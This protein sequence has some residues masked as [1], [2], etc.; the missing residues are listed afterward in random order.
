MNL[1]NHS[2]FNLSGVPGSQ[3]LDHLIMINADYYTPVDSMLIPDSIAP[4][5]GTPMDLRD[6]V[7]LNLHID[8]S[9]E[10]IVR[11]RGFDHNW[12][13]NTNGDVTKLAAKAISPVSG[14]VLEVYTKEP[15]IQFYSGNFMSGKDIGKQEVTYR[16]EIGRASCRERV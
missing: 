9:S 15:G 6:P 3:V 13:L 2:Y 7:A 1:T 4:V 14:I 5:E 11:G 12:V 8:S 16:R 10:Q